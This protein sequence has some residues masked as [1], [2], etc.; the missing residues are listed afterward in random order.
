VTL[1][2]SG[3]NRAAFINAREDEAVK[4][5]QAY[6]EK[7]KAS[8]PEFRQ[9]I[10]QGADRH[11]RLEVNE[12]LDYTMTPATDLGVA[13]PTLDL[14]CRIVRVVSR[15]AGQAAPLNGPEPR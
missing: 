4:A 7:T 8:A 10:L 14:C 15:A 11:R 2:D 13:G 5:V 3:F 1:Q 12:T 9:S 6:G